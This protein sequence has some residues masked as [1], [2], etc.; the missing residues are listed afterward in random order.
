MAEENNELSS[1]EIAKAIKTEA[2]E[3]ERERLR[4]AANE[5]IDACSFNGVKDTYLKIALS[6][7]KQPENIMLGQLM[8]KI[9]SALMDKRKDSIEKRAIQSFLKDFHNFEKY[10]NEIRHM[11]ESEGHI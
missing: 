8:K 10:M 5:F 1:D 9:I 3:K 7:D 4:K 2:L 11:Q 6:K